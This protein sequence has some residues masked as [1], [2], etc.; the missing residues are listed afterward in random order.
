MPLTTGDLPG[1]AAGDL[2]LLLTGDLDLDL[3]RTGEADLSLEADLSSFLAPPSIFIGSSSLSE[4]PALGDLSSSDITLKP[5]L[6]TRCM[7][8]LDAVRLAR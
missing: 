6:D 2:D 5:V 8:R 1:D 4:S 3:S 7:Q